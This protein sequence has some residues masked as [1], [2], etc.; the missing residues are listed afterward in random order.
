MK[1]FKEFM[2][3][4][5]GPHIVFNKKSKEVVSVHKDKDSAYDEMIHKHHF[6]PDLTVL[7]KNDKRLFK[8]YGVSPEAASHLG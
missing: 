8:Q 6:H 1:T 4:E 3:E 5:T 2:F 7:G